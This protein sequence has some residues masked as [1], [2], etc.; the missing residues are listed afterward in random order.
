[1]IA[2]GCDGATGGVT[3][4]RRLRERITETITIGFSLVILR[5]FRHAGISPYS[6]GHCVELSAG[7]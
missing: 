7:K 6:I 3:R 1:M 5:A 4:R 2:E